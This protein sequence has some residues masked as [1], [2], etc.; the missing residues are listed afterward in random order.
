MRITMTKNR[1]WTPPEDRRQSFDYLAGKAYTVK[2]EWGEAMVAEGVA[3]EVAV[4]KAESA[5]ATSL[6][7][8]DPRVGD[9]TEA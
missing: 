2:R 7:V 1:F 9:T 6:Q 5:T 3:K 4:K 8:L